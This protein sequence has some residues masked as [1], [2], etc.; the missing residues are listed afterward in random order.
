MSVILQIVMASKAQLGVSSSKIKLQKS[1]VSMSVQSAADV[2]E[3]A[4]NH[5]PLSES[6]PQ[7]CLMDRFPNIFIKKYAYS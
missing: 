5:Y 7:V 2:T 4:Q 1:D 3:T 6:P